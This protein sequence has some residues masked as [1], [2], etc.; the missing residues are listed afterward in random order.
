MHQ[1][2]MGRRNGNIGPISR[3]I[4]ETAQNID[5]YYKSLIRSR[6]L[7][8][9]RLNDPRLPQDTPFS[10]FYVAFRIGAWTEAREI[11]RLIMASSVS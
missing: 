3:Y 10:E 9:Q 8:I 1:V 7:S 6:M 4:S 5:N 11:H 2:Q